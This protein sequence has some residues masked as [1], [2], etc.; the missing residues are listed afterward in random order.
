MNNM[1]AEQYRADGELTLSNDEL[2]HR[3]K[4]GDAELFEL[5]MR[6]LYR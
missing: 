1:A 5:L 6:R 2:V 3:I 4:R